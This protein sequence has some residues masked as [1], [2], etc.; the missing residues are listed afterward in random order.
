M[1]KFG[2]KTKT[3]QEIPTSALPDIIFMLLF[4]FMVTTVMRE[5]TLQVKNA[6]PTASQIQ[7]LENKS[8]VK[9]IYIG[10]PKETEKFGEAPRIQLNDALAIADDIPEFIVAQ[11]T[12]LDEAEQDKMTISLKV[13]R[14]AK[15]GIVSDVRQQ[16]REA[17]ALKLNYSSIASKISE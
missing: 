6:L 15:M 7:K 5:V 2:K 16:L 8:L 13:D 17:N 14:D 3:S 9:Y 12:T 1:A 11:R 10:E 4:F